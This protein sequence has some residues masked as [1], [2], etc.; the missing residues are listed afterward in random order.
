MGIQINFSWLLRSCA[1]L[2][3]TTAFDRY[4]VLTPLIALNII[5]DVAKWYIALTDVLLRSSR[6]K[7]KLLNRL[8]LSKMYV[9]K[10]AILAV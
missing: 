2:A 5:A 7:S 4:G 1:S 3:M 6:N 10:G 8:H 9:C